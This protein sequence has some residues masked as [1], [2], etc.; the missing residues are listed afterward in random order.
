MTKITEEQKKQMLGLF[1]DGKKVIDVALALSISP[2]VASYWLNPKLRQKR[3]NWQ[4]QYFKN[5]PKEK[6]REIYKSRKEYNKIYRKNRY[7]NDPEFR[8]KQKERSR[9]DWNNKK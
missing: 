6:K 8:E 4:K 9:K 3:I 5:L 2:S 7:K 1:S